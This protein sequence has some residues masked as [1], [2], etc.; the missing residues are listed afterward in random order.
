[1]ISMLMGYPSHMGGLLA[2]TSG[3]IYATELI[4]GSLNFPTSL[5]PCNSIHVPAQVPPY[6][7]SDYYCKTGANIYA[8]QYHFFL[9]D[10]LWDG[11]QCIGEEAPYCTHPKMPWFFKTLNETTTEDIEL[12]VYGDQV[13]TNNEDTSLQVIEL[14]VY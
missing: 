13:E 4:L 14:F 7:G 2:S 3:L 12:R 9:N 1:M 5:C 10:T 6:V 8:H 11:Q